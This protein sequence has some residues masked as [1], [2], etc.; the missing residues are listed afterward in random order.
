MSGQLQQEVG[1]LEGRAN[2]IWGRGTGSSPTDNLCKLE[3]VL[4]G[5]QQATVHVTVRSQRAGVVHSR[6]VLETGAV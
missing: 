4:R 6:I 2:K 5:P 1:H 3:W